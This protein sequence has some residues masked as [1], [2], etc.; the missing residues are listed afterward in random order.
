MRGAATLRLTLLNY[1]RA[2][3]PN[4]VRRSSFSKSRAPPQ[5]FD[6][7]RH[8]DQDLNERHCLRG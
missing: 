3:N 5:D 4:R 6:N 2:G 7:I 1:A 8:N